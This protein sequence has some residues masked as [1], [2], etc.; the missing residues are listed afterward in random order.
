MKTS[1]HQE[2]KDRTSKHF[3]AA[4]AMALA[5]VLTASVAAAQS[6]YPPPSLLAAK[7]WQ[8]ALE[9]P[10]SESPL[11]DQ[12]GQ[13][14]AVNQPRGNIWFL[15]GN[16][17]GTTVRTVTIPAGKALFFPVVNV[18]D[19]EDGTT[20]PGGTTVFKVH[21]P[22]QTA[23][24]IVSEIIATASGSCTVDGTNVPITAANLEQ[25]VPFTLLL[26]DHNLLGVP[27]G[28]YY[29]AFDSGYYVLLNPLSPGQHT[30]HFTGGFNNS[31]FLDV[32]YNITIQ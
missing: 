9:T 27:A 31:N 19:V 11:T 13:R 25:S 30:I 10:S 8:W 2:S 24:S 32:T 16:L 26:P 14:A 18:V 17:G 21:Q 5:L 23:Q 29:P 1:P 7:W 28:V 22:L 15:A 3:K 12:S 6:A 4:G 20:I